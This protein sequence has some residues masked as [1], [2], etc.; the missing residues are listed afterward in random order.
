M[1]WFQHYSDAHQ[2]PKIK[3]LI[4]VFGASGYYICFST[5]EIIAKYGNLDLKLSL[6]KYGISE[7]SEDLKVSKGELIRTWEEMMDMGLLSRKWFNKGILY[8]KKLGEYQDEY[9]RKLKNVRS[10]S[11]ATQDKVSVHNTT[12][13]NTKLNK[14][15]GDFSSSKEW[16]DGIGWIEPLKNIFK[17]KK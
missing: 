10:K 12:L 16:I 9:T 1:K 17:W 4:K 15:K 6:K 7:I 14:T 2:H 13:H 8:S 11:G 5:W 3:K